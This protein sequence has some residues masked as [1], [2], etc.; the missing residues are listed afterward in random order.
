MFVQLQLPC[1]PRPMSSAADSRAK[2][3]RPPAS[4]PGSKG[5]ARGSG[6]NSTGSSASSTPA[7][8]SSRTAFTGGEPGCPSCGA[9]STSAGIPACRFACRP[10]TLGPVTNANAPSYLPTLL[11]CDHR[12]KPRG[13]GSVARG[14]GLRLG[15]VLLPTLTSSSATRGAQVRGGKAQGGPSLMEVL[16]T[17]TV[18]GN[19]NRKG[20]SPRSGDGLLTA[21]QVRIR[22]TLV[23][24]ADRESCKPH[25]RPPLRKILPTLLAKDWRSGLARGPTNSRPVTEVICAFLGPEEWGLLNPCWAEVFMGFPMGWTWPSGPPDGPPHVRERRASRRAATPASPPNPV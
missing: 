23:A 16:P 14:G 9:P 19:Y 10:L 17:L 24:S 13:R 20:L 15:N 5:R 6:T 2:T 7:G 25:G 21:L 4:A 22:P 18:K 12:L 3:C 8:S 11:E 1:C